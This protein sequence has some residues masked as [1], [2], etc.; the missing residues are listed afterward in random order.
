MIGVDNDPLSIQHACDNF[1][2]IKNLKNN[3]NFVVD[4]MRLFAKNKENIQADVFVLASAAYYISRED[5]S[6]LFVNMVANNNIKGNIPFY[7]R[8]RSKKDFRYGYGK[9]IGPSRFKM[10]ED[11]VTGE[12]GAKIEFYSENEIVNILKDKLNLRDYD[13]M[14]LEAQNKQNG[15]IIFNSDIIVWGWIN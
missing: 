8:V 14:T 7:I 13:V 9:K 1:N 10:P 5:L 11:G 4:D 15:V 2:L 3:S 12:N 6:S